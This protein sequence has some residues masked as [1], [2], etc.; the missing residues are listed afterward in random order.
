MNQWDQKPPIGELVDLQ[1]ESLQPSK[2]SSD[3][4]VR[5]S[6][7]N[8]SWLCNP[9]VEKASYFVNFSVP[10]G[11]QLL[12]DDR[13]HL[14]VDTIKLIEATPCTRLSQTREKPTHHLKIT[15]KLTIIGHC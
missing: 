13:Q 9:R 7:P 6:H 15:S 11:E 5:K 8:N 10:N 4:S 1:L 14:D 2:W 12:S 3:T